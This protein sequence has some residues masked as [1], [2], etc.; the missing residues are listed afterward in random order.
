MDKTYL[1]RRL[2]EF[3]PSIASQPISQVALLTDNGAVVGV[4][5]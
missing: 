1:G 4:S 3:S 5:G 2:A